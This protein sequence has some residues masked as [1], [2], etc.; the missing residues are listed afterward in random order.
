[1]LEMQ[2]INPEH[3]NPA[4]SEEEGNSAKKK[5]LK[6]GRLTMIPIQK[7]LIKLDLM[8]KQ[9]LDWL[10]AYHAEVFGKI[11]PLLEPDSP[12]MKW[13]QKSCEKIGREQ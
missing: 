5:F 8:T 10:D 3:N 12:A 11:S 7:N 13:L 9:E 6:F 1:L 2:Y 4:E